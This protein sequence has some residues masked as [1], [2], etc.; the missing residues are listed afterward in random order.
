MRDE[1]QT[2]FEDI[3]AWEDAGR[4]VALATVIET[5]GSSPR[6]VGSHLAVNDNG[7]FAGS[8][9]AGCVEGNVIE[10]A[11]SIMTDGA[12]SR[13]DF[14]VADRQA[15]DVGLTCGGRIAIYV[16]NVAGR[17]R[18]LLR[19]T[20]AACAQKRPVALVTRLRDGAVALLED[21]DLDDAAALLAGAA[22]R[23]AAYR[24]LRA[25]HSGILAE[26]DD[27]FV[28][29]YPRPAR[30]FLIGAVHIAQILAPLAS[31]VGF[32]PLVIDPRRAYA[33]PGR[34]GTVALSTEWPDDALRQLDLAAGDA[35]VTL[36]H[37]PKLDDAALAVALRSPAF[38]IGALGSRRT[39]ARRT[40][41]LEALGLGDVVPRIHAPVGL[42]LGGRAPA[43]IAVSIMA[44][45]IARKYAS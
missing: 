13:L 28:R 27:L 42:P 39:H 37:D 41:R 7:E 20:M 6:A 19:R 25:G 3:A 31:Q 38:Y 18:A 5:W 45:I 23:D 8:V 34:F 22:E 12:A 36:A 10:R 9:S 44:D 30:L 15:M 21:D 32:E 33:T 24:A 1:L 2:L 14:D 11:L 40:E 17:R 29:S 35:V 43:E 26:A 4:R 16:E